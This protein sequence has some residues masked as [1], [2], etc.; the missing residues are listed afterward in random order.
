MKNI[1]QISESHLPPRN[2]YETSYY[3]LK[4]VIETS[5][6]RWKNRD[7]KIYVAIIYF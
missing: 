6:L 2:Q 4:N 1:F 3:T 5:R 7:L